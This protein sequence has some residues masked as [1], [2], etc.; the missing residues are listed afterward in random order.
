MQ[1]LLKGAEVRLGLST[2][3]AVPKEELTLLRRRLGLHWYGDGNGYF[4]PIFQHKAM[5]LGRLRHGSW[6]SK[7]A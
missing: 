7:F 2:D 6:L 3:T 5:L 1:V 4:V